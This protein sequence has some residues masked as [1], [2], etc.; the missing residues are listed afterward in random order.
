AIVE[1]ACE[2]QE[3]MIMQFI[4]DGVM[5]VFGGP[6]K[7]VADHARRAV[8]AAIVLQRALAERNSSGDERLEAGIGICTGAMIAGNLG[9]G[10]RVTYTVV[11]DA[12][13]QASRVQAMTREHD[14]AILLTASTRVG[15]GPLDDAPLRSCGTAT[16][17]GID[18][19]V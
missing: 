11:G 15:V 10:E 18:T 4:G 14:A 17:K 2:A 3:G 8:L 6:L 12:V 13:N 9:A 16:L 5:A 19:S 7:P 1:H